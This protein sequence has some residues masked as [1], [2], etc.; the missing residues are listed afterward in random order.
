MVGREIE[1]IG[2]LGHEAMWPVVEKVWASKTK[3]KL[4]LVSKGVVLI[5]R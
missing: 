1:W 3:S 2:F 5:F 4:C